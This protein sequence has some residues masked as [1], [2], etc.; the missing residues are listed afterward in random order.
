MS[1]RLLTREVY[2]QHTERREAWSASAFD[3]PEGCA[4]DDATKRRWRIHTGP[5]PFVAPEVD[6]ALWLWRITDGRHYTSITVTFHRLVLDAERPSLDRS[7]RAA[8][9]TRGEAAVQACLT[10]RE[11]PREIRFHHPAEQPSYW[12]GRR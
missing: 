4:V 1:M 9:D 6:G 8:I 3:D 11:P 5:F 10:W 2:A 12:G 7:T